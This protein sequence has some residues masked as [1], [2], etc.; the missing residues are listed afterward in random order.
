MTTAEDLAVCACTNIT[1]Q[2][3]L[4]TCVQKSCGF[5]DQNSQ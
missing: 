4:S 2:A 1:M 3:T 5:V